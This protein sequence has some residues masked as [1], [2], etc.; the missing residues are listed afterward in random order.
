LHRLSSSFVL[1]YHGCDRAIAESLLAGTPFNSS[2]NAW[3]W[4]GH[5]VYFWEAN[6]VRGLEFARLQQKWRARSGR[7]PQIREP[8]V[9][10]AVI[11]LG[12]CLD[13]FSSAGTEAVARAYE[14]FVKYCAKAGVPVPE[15]SGG[16]DLLYR[17]LDCAVINH[18][19]TVLE[20]ARHPAFDSVKGPFRAGGTIYP[21]S[22]FYRRTHI[23][24][25]VRNLA[26]I[27]GVFRVPDD[28][29]EA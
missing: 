7:F 8:Y 24:I 11:E 10:G 12:L 13:L 4:L 19:H 1:G 2:Q 20:R 21:N 26:C 17:G 6:P 23:Q 27:K 15:N 9:V 18:L 28:Q 14:D 5:G 3:D 29:L 25:C 16:H 22:G